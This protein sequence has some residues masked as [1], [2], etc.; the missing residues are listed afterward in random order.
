MN[1]LTI[2]AVED[3]SLFRS[4]L[5]MFLNSSKAFELKFI[6]S[7]IEELLEIFK[8]HDFQDPKILL[9]DNGLP[10]RKGI[11]SIPFIKDKLPNTHIIVLTTFED[12]EDIFLA[13]RSGASAYLSKRTSIKK[14]EDAIYTVERGGAY[15]SPGIA[16]KVF[17]YFHLPQSN[18][19]EKLTER[20][21][22]IVELITKGMSYKSVGE[23]LDISI[24]TVRDHIKKVYRKLNINSKAE[25]IKMRFPGQSLK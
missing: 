10:G 17:K 6:C 25:L 21:K 18:K 3:D 22:D 9:L 12:E 13:L 19:M 4:S 20:Q 16:K 8:E 2:G 14:I 24:D 15:M 5:E 7:S 23:Q 1:K 11:V